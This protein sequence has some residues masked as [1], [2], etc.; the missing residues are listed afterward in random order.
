MII[1]ALDS[2]LTSCSAAVIK[3][4]KIISEL[5][6]DRMRGQAERLMPMCL[7]A[8]DKADVSF[9]DLTA[10]AVTRGPGAFTGVRIGLATAKGLALALGLPLV[11]VTTLE[12]VAQNLA[13]AMGRRQNK[14]PIGR[15]AIAL[16]ARRSEVYLQVF[17]IMDG[18]GIPILGPMS[19]PEL[20]P[21]LRA[22]SEPVAAPLTKI[23]DYLDD[24]ITHI[25]GTGA[26][27]VKSQL[28]SE[29]TQ[30]IAF[31]TAQSQPNAG[32]VGLIAAK[33]LRAG[34]MAHNITPLYL[35]APDAVAA[36]A[37]TYAFQNQ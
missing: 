4:G 22:V 12:A 18:D 24:K 33:R 15:A 36:K 27:L 3:D 25:V 11:A 35:R 28:T 17:D 23:S 37:V 29:F 13:E 7:E 5:F 34:D 16:D 9:E 20:G 30:K 8:C 14:L 19:G 32:T 21:I 26:D 2:A 31:P 1:L 6:E 10:I